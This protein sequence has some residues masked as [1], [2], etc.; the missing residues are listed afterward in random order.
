MSAYVFIELP[1]ELRDWVDDPDNAVFPVRSGR[2]DDVQVSGHPRPESI[3]HELERYL[4]EYPA[5][6]ARFERAGG[7]LAFRTALELFTNGLKEESLQFYQLALRL[8]SEDLLTRINYAVSLHALRYRDEALRQYAEAMRRTTP[9]DNFRVWI[10]AAQIH[11]FKREYE[12]V[13]ELL[14]PLVADAPPDDAE[15]WNLYG[16]ARTALIKEQK[17]REEEKARE[18]AAAE[19][20][21]PSCGAKLPSADMRFCGFCGAKL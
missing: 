2:A 20:A 16:E 4:E 5:K 7:Q 9:R 15:Y 12:A 3:L 1:A 10:L 21:C 11:L 8:R 18:A 14:Q 19:P 13:V 6:Q 17:A